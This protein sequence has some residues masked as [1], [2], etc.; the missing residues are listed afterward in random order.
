L[1]RKYRPKT[2]DEVFG[3]DAIVQT[4]KNQVK[5]NRISHAYLFHGSRGSGKTSTAR[6]LAKAVNCKNAVDGNP[7]NACESCTNNNGVNPDVIEIDAASNNGVDNIR[8]LIDEVNYKPIYSKY[9]VY[10]IDEVHMLSTSAFNALLKT[11]EEPPKHV[12]FILATTEYYKVPTTIQS[13]CQIFNFKNLSNYEIQYCLGS[14]IQKENIQCSQEALEFIARKAD[15]SMR[16][17]I[18]IL[19]QYISQMSL[20]NQE[21]IGVEQLRNLFGYIDDDTIKLI[22]DH[23][24]NHNIHEVINIIHELYNNGKNLK[25]I[26]DQLYQYYF[27]LYLNSFD[28]NNED[29]QTA[30]KKYINILGE[31][32]GQL[33]YSTQPLITIEIA[34]VKLCRPDEE[35]MY[36]SLMRRIT[37]LEDQIKELKSS[38]N[39]TKPNPFDKNCIIYYNNT[40]KNSFAIGE[41]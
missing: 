6:I 33:N 1:Y 15:G 36:K 23:I 28:I 10:I 16:D 35:S 2:F 11:L 14:I 32:T 41:N 24:E 38:N 34:L 30:Y 19:N 22:T 4:L 29:K 8:Q 3:Q 17:A 26:L 7:C 5:S 21:I 40:C 37:E 31:T 9:K 27:K 20:I 18:S 39:S 25:F 13:R 12:I